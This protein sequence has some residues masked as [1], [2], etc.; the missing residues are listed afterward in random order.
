MSLKN[1]FLTSSLSFFILVNSGLAQSP[2]P[3]V[4]AKAAMVMDKK[5]KRILYAKNQH[6]KLPI[7]SITKIMTA[8]LVLENL[9]LESYTQIS[10]Q[11]SQ[12]K[13]SKVHLRKGEE[14]KNL[15]LLYALLMSSANDAAIGLAEA[16]SGNEVD[17]VKI[18]NRKAGKLNLANSRFVDSTGLSSQGQSSTCIELAKI[19]IK[20]SRYP[21]FQE[22]MRTKY[23]VITS[24]S[25]RSIHLKNHNKLLWQYPKL[26][27]GKT[28][29]TL[30]AKHCFTGE[31]YLNKK[32][33]IIVILGS[34]KPWQDL[35]TLARFCETVK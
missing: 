17:F 32:S 23:K 1:K 6:L 15:D 31:L 29:Y 10:Y 12:I 25:D 30:K 4:T 18:M 33:Y 13:S 11:A 19:W 28:G 22:I 16:V 14:W 24:N 3:F 21:V 2:K 8:L 27:I 34:E 26:F 35:K 9:N 5:N 7:A 20:V